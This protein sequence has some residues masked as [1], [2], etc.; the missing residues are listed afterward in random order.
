MAMAMRMAVFMSMLGL[1][2]MVMVMFMPMLMAG[3]V[4]VG[5]E[6]RQ[7][8]S[9]LDSVRRYQARRQAWLPPAS[10]DGA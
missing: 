3:R 7:H 5:L 1:M 2:A 6:R 8:Q 10:G 4:F 9:G